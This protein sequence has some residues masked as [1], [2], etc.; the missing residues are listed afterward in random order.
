MDRSHHSPPAV[1]SLPQQRP[2]NAAHAARSSLAFGCL[3]NGQWA[4]CANALVCKISL[5]RVGDSFI[6]AFNFSTR[7]LD[8]IAPG[9]LCRPT[10]EPVHPTAAPASAVESTIHLFRDGTFSQQ[11]FGH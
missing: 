5:K 8:Y 6:N 3:L 4:V 1:D 7:S 9:R 2:G 10:A 11:P